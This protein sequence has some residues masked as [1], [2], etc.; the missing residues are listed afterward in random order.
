MAEI[1]EAEGDRDVPICPS[2]PS[3]E[4]TV[5]ADASSLLHLACNDLRDGELMHGENFNLFAAMSALEIMDPKMDSG[6]VRTYYSVDEAIEY[7][8]APIPLSFDKTVDVQRT[9]DIMDHLLAC[10]ATWHKGCSLAQTVF[11]CLYLLRPDI[12]SSH[13]LLHS[14]CNVIRAT[15]NAVV[16]TVSD[17]RT[18]EEEDLFTMTH[19]LPLKVDGDDKCLT[20]LHAVEETIARQLR[21]CKATL[22]KKRVTEDI[23]PLQN[24]PDLEEGYCKALLCRLRFRKHLYHVVTNMKRPQGRGLEL[25]KKHIAC[26]F[27]ELDSMSESVEFL[28]STVAQ[29]TLEDGT[30]NETTASGCQ[31]IGFDSTLNSRLSAPTPPRAIQTISWKKA[32]EYFQKLLHELEI[33]CS[34]N[35]DPVF[36]GVLRFVVEFQ[37]FQPELVAR[38]HLQAG[39]YKK[40]TKY[41]G[42]LANVLP[43][44]T[45]FP[46]HNKY[47]FCHL[48]SLFSALSITEFHVACS[49]LD[50][51]RGK[52]WK[53]MG[54]APTLQLSHCDKL[55]MIS[56]VSIGMVS[57]FLRRGDKGLCTDRKV[58]PS[59]CLLTQHRLL[60]MDLEV[61]GARKKKAVY[62]QPKIKWGASTKGK[63]QKLG[64]KLLAMG[65]WRN[66]GD[67][68][69]MWTMTANCI[70]EA[71]REVLGVSKSCS[72]GHKGDGWWNEEVQGKVEA[73]KAAYLKLVGST[74]E[75]ER[76][77]YRECYKKA[78]REAKL[79]VMAAK[80]ASLK[81][82]D[83]NIVLGELENSESRGDF[84]FCRRIKC[85]E[86]DA[87]IRK[88]SRGK[89]TG[90]DEIPVEFWK[91]SGRVGLEWLTSLFNVIFKTKKMPED[92]RNIHKQYRERKKDLHMVFIDLEKTYDKVSREVLWRCLEVSRVPI[93][94]IRVIKDMYE[95]AKTR[96]RSAG[97]DSEH[98]LVEMG[99]H[100]GSTLIPF[101]FALALDVL[102]RYI[103]GRVPWCMLFADDIVLIDETRGGVNAR[104]EVWRQMLESK[105]FKLSRSKTEYLECK[106]SDERHE[107]EVEVKID[108]QVIPTRDSFKYL[109]S[110]IQDNGKID[111]YVTHRIGA[112]WMRWRLASGVLC[113]KNVPP[114]LK[115]KFYRVVV[116]P[117]MLYG[118]EC[119]PVKK[120]YV[121]KMTVAEMKMLRWMCGHTRKDK[122][123]NEVIRDKMGVASMETKLRE[124]RL[125][126]FGHVKRRDIDAP[127]LLIQD[128]KLY[129]RDPVFA[130]ICKASLLPEVAKNHDIQKNETLVQLGQLLI[131]LLRVLCTNISWQRRKLGKILQD[132]RIIHVQLELAFRKEFG[133][134]STTSSNENICMKI[135]RHIL[136]WVEEQTYWI[137]ARFL[138]LG[139]EL[140]LYSAGEYCMVYWYMYIILIKLGE[141]TH[142][143]TMTS[144]EIS[145]RKGKKKREFVKD[146]G[147]DYQLPPSILFLQCHVYLAEGLTM[148]LAALRNERQIYLSA[149]PFNSEH[150]RFVQHFELLLKAC[151][152]DHV[153]YYSFQETTAHARLS[154]LSMYNC[155]K[156]AQRSAK[157][158]RS[159]F[160]NDPDKMSEL[161]RIEQVAEHNSV[162]LG[163]ISRLGTPDPSLKVQFEFSHH[164]FF[165][166]AVVKRS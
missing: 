31:P 104:L 125:R 77:S 119:W 12:T 67:A 65:A 133:D 149:G 70:R 87:A 54:R 102:R 47:F 22:S 36:E 157:D 124:S 120:S 140:D 37:K 17:T 24:N 145:K 13:A 128:A 14:Y 98:F 32:V 139:F 4:Q 117:A 64:E 20:M 9:I 26:C 144:N 132:W 71:A 138:M 92:W 130:V 16:S 5:W 148:M 23:E 30:E 44:I 105:G 79:A 46:H 160:S 34:Y 127:H 15:C 52:P 152:P 57:H 21:A 99:L 3:G 48:A 137:A 72:G 74:D 69:S 61:K 58:I 50:A 86:V 121:Q 151:L 59:A 81:D 75:E 78:R 62:G 29:G 126:W 100:Q 80:T 143:R 123:R 39:A 6:M 115:G 155:F 56:I 113:D 60:V 111:E 142:M 73:K 41:V 106:F 35:L 33:I 159:S 40:C 110:I 136:I 103:Q 28:R 43:I 147:K 166:T 91:E 84:G 129:G 1:S 154:N 107:E 135:C 68:S 27:Q 109:G 66:S 150:E 18:N 88:M 85:E 108:T 83:R 164:P 90:P 162:A 89:A 134:I 2:I 93:A 10:E 158:L 163:L 11:S 101:L 51:P 95:G 118:A 112:G 97:G 53:V 49:L 96:V 19:G 45:L 94:Y 42:V 131:T 156:E 141:K 63:A 146:G 76:R 55:S 114:R 38:A 7:G 82:W 116:R 25:A 165:A 153:S 161:R 122:I 8:A